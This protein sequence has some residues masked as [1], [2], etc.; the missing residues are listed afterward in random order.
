MT[1]TAKAA[2][3]ARVLTGY[4]SHKLTGRAR[5]VSRMIDAVA[6][7]AL[8]TVQ[9]GGLVKMAG[10]SKGARMHKRIEWVEVV[11]RFGTEGVCAV[12]TETGHVLTCRATN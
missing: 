4:N 8:L 5:R 1:K 9:V 11:D 10:M 12:D 7:A 2:T 3:A 6:L